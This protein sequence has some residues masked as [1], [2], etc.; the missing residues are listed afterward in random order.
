MH[1]ALHD[2]TNFNIKCPL[3]II[4]Y[5]SILFRRHRIRKMYQPNANFS[6][7]G[8]NYILKTIITFL[9]K[10]MEVSI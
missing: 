8:N 7:N 3:M 1:Q 6:G 2:V 4:V 10:I 5:Y 9:K